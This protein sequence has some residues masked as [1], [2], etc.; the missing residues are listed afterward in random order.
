MD[1]KAYI[2]S[3]I[4]EDYC[5]GILN[6]EESKAVEEQAQLHPEIKQ[7]IEDYL[8]TF[9]RY[10]L[11]SNFYPPLYV[12]DKTLELLKNLQLEE[13]AKL[14]ELPLLNKY[15]DHNNWLQIVKPVLPEKLN[16]KMFIRVLR[17]DKKVS[18]TI[19]WTAVDY[20]DEVHQDVEEC[21]IILKGRCRC[22][23]EDEVVELGPGGFLEIPMNKHHDVK[24]I[25]HPVLAV[26]QR[27]KVA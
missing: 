15:S 4:I 22:Y 11:D 24:V 21:F 1:I 9:E 26:V 6:T 14:D 3:G 10:A 2:V 7:E 16:D 19:I 20:P 27:I 8:N 5:L 17:N 25:E 18:Q 23:I 13:Q 12:K